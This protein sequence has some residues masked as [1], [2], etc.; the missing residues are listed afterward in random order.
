[1]FARLGSAQISINN[2]DEGITIWKEKDMLLM[3]SVEGY[4]GAYLLT[5]RKTGEVISMTLWD[6]E[7]D[8]IADE[9]S[10]LHKNQVDMYK[11]LLVGEP[12]FQRYEVSAQHKI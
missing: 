7:V 3:D 8:A 6:D 9:Q 2:L 5:N 4:I 10:N 11:D 1:M 12:T